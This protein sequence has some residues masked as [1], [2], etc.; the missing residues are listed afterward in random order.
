MKEYIRRWVILKR[1]T[2]KIRSACGP[3]IRDHEKGLNCGQMEVIWKVFEEFEDLGQVQRRGVRVNT[4]KIGSRGAVFCLEEISGFYADLWRELLWGNLVWVF[5]G[6]LFG[7]PRGYTEEGG[8][9]VCF[10][11]NFKCWWG[12]WVGG[13]CVGCVNW[14]ACRF[15]S[16]IRGEV[17][18]YC[19]RG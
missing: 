2:N 13:N 19:I 1:V 9:M 14:E 16:G 3:L 4:P 11:G 10:W 12:F 8:T 7:V 18:G 5:F 17:F 15:R 6:V